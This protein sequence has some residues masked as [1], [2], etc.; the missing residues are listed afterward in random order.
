MRTQRSTIWSDAL[1]A[2]AAVLRSTSSKSTTPSE[3]VPNLTDDAHSS[4]SDL[5]AGFLIEAPT[6]EKMTVC[7]RVLQ[8]ALRNLDRRYPVKK[9]SRNDLLPREEEASQERRVS[10][11]SLSWSDPAA[12]I[13]PSRERPTQSL[14]EGA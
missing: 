3:R 14:A 9:R 5:S 10:P 2:T 7:L 11:R 13:G 12:D 8:P 4:K 6:I 1:T